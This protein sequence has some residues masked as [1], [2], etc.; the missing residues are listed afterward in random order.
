VGLESP[1]YNDDCFSKVVVN[2][3]SVKF[4]FGD[5]V[6]DSLN[7]KVVEYSLLKVKE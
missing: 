5:K 7:K 2:D 4:Y 1:E 3:N 6:D